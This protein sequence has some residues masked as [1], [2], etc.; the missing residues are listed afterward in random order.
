MWIIDDG[1]VLEFRANDIDHE[2]LGILISEK[3]HSRIY[4]AK[5]NC[6]NEIASLISAVEWIQGDE[7]EQ[8]I[9]IED[10]NGNLITQKIKT[11]GP[12]VPVHVGNYYQFVDPVLTI[13]DRDKNKIGEFYFDKLHDQK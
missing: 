9:T 12:S 6:Q 2:I 3:P 7:I 1:G 4:R 11:P 10:A 5:K 8:E 13:F